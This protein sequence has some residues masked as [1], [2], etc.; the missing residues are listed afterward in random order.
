MSASALT[1]TLESSSDVGQGI[2]AVFSIAWAAGD[3]VTT[4]NTVS[5]QIAGVKTNKPPL[6]VISCRSSIGNVT[7]QYVKGTTLAN[8][9][10]KLWASANTEYTAGALAAGQAAEVT[11]LTVLLPKG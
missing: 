2:L 10:L 3:Y 5:L 8:G 1:A 4:G 7:P 11:K 9:K 6:A